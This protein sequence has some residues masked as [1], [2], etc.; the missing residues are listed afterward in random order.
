LKLAKRKPAA[1]SARGSRAVRQL[2]RETLPDILAGRLSRSRRTRQATYAGKL[3]PAAAALDWQGDATAL[4]RQ[5]GRFAP[6]PGA[7]TTWRGERLKLHRA[8]PLAER[9]GT[10]GR[11]WRAGGGPRRCRRQGSVRV[12]ELQPPGGRIMTARTS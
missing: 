1:N 2:L 5:V 4:A 8:V 10:P 11:V 3:D 7:W 9:E 6:K 12:L